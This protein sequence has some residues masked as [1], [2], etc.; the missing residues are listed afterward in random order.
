ME[1]IKDEEEG[2]VGCHMMKKGVGGVASEKKRGSTVSRK[3]HQ[4]LVESLKE[5]ITKKEKEEQ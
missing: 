3:A 4:A 1:K 5:R 2:S